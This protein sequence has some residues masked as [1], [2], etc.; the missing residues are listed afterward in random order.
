[1]SDSK[2]QDN[3]IVENTEEIMNVLKGLTLAE[4]NTIIRNLQSRVSNTTK[5]L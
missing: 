5:I 2:M 1:M 4:F 3:K